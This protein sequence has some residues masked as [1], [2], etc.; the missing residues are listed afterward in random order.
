MV[1]AGRSSWLISCRCSASADPSDPQIPKSV[2]LCRT[3]STS[4][5]KQLCSSLSYRGIASPLQVDPLPTVHSRR[6]H[7]PCAL[8]QLS[9]PLWALPATYAK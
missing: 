5:P 3:S 7:R 8:F 1:A 6:R 2:S 9:Q 4:L